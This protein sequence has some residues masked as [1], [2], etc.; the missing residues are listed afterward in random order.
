MLVCKTW[1]NDEQAENGESFSSFS[2][3]RYTRIAEVMGGVGEGVGG[4]SQTK[5][6]L[7]QISN[8]SDQISVSLISMNIN[9]AIAK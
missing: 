4:D 7:I 1:F 2:P 8:F 6:K 5:P 9:N 3:V